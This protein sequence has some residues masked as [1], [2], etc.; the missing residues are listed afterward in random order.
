MT[1]NYPEDFQWMW[2]SFTSDLLGEQVDTQPLHDAKEEMRKQLID[3]IERYTP[4]EV[5]YVV[6]NAVK[7]LLELK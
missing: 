4:D 2:E 6:M 1:T 3:T 7:E 5:K